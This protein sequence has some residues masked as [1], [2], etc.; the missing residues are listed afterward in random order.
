METKINI[1]KKEENYPGYSKYFLNLLEMNICKIKY[2]EKE[3]C[4]GF[5]CKIYFKPISEYLPVLIINRYLFNKDDLFINV[6]INIILSNNKKV[7]LLIDESRKMYT[8][9]EKYGF[10]IIEIKE[11]DDLDIHSFLEIDSNIMKDKSEIIYNNNKI[12]LLYYSFEQKSLN[13]KQEYLANNKIMMPKEESLSP[14]KITSGIIKNINSDNQKIDFYSIDKKISIGSPI[15]NK[16]NNKIIGIIKSC[17]KETSKSIGIFLKGPI[18]EFIN[19]TLENKNTITIIYKNILKKN[20]ILFGNDFILLNKN[21][22]KMIINGIEKEI[23]ETDDYLEEIKYKKNV[24]YLKIKLNGIDKLTNL[25]CMFYDCDTLRSLP[26]ISKWDTKN[27]VN[28]RS[29]FNGCSSLT[30]LSGISKWDISQ[31]TDISFLFNKC[32]SLKK[33]P[34]ISQWNTSNITSMIGVFNECPSITELPDISK[35]NTNSV[36]EMTCIFCG[37]TSLVSLPDISKWNTDSAISMSKIFSLC[38]K[39]THLPDISKWNTSNAKNIMNMF[40]Y[41]S[42]LK[43]LPDIS[44]WNTKNVINMKELFKNC[45]SLK[46]IPD[47]SKWNTN[48]VVIIAGMF[49][50]CSSLLNL[51]DISKWNTANILN[52]S[53]LFHGASSLIT[54]PDISK[55]DTSKV[56]HMELLFSKCYSLSVLPNISKWETEKVKSMHYMFKE[57]ISLVRLPDLSK[58]NFKNMNGIFESCYS[59]ASIGKLHISNNNRKTLA[60]NCISLLL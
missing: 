10:I 42:S 24:K 52:M 5:F 15:I 26:D 33:I 12:N 35:W 34:D 49:E 29:M 11:D 56:Q 23:S 47:I 54:L 25:Y 44:N 19:D 45:F 18:K 9:K 32:S 20:I 41:C 22:C 48:K 53:N 40:E 2:K 14:I 55:W 31:V 3:E 1:N 46:E 7:T 6:K 39:L 43:E 58:W 51:P 36:I 21:N 13:P 59:L 8:E 16:D 4:N 50:N 37:C 28:I 30:E 27:I 38:K 57:C 60:N 17:E